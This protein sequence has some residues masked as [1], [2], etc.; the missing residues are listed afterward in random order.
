MGTG[1]MGRE[2]HSTVVNDTLAGGECGE[3]PERHCRCSTASTFWLAAAASSEKGSPMLYAARHS[4]FDES[5]SQ[6]FATNRKGRMVLGP[7]MS[8]TRI[9]VLGSQL[10]S[11]EKKSLE[12]Q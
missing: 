5:S 1:E 3:H 7:G 4:R 9:P 6:I 11:R 2:R 8:L 10:R 12:A